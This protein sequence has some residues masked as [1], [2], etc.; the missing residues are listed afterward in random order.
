MAI[1]FRSDIIP[2][3]GESVQMRQLPDESHEPAAPES[4]WGKTVVSRLPEE[5]R[6]QPLVIVLLSLVAGVALDRYS[7]PPIDGTSLGHSLGVWWS[8]A[9]GSLVGWRLASSTRCNQ[10]AVWLLLC[11]VAFTGAAWH[12]ARWSLFSTDEI[13]R[14]ADAANWRC[15][16]SRSASAVDCE[17]MPW[18]FAM[19]SRGARRR[20]R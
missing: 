1:P 16:K 18:L 8:L 2:A 9:A 12:D 6:Y 10:L 15:V 4:R 20:A 17:P 13:G 14:Y 7:G 3:M 19:G 5:P 11:A